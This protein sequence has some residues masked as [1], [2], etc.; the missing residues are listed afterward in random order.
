MTNPK[1]KAYSIKGD[2]SM[3]N[4]TCMDLRNADCEGRRRNSANKQKGQP[5]LPRLKG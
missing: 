1:F 3:K 5:Q 4:D 2:R